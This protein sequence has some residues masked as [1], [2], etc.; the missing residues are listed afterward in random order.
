MF[1]IPSF[2]KILVLVLVVLAVWYGF[3]LIGQLDRQRKEL[4]RRNRDKPAAR[5]GAGI[6]DM[7]KCGA[8][9][10]YLPAHGAASCG[11]ADCPY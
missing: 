5:A 2:G 4:A 8:C 9:G 7:I 3:R 6:E 1:A 11:K 10:T